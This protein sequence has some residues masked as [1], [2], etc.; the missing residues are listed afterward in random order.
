MC[1]E[2]VTA[3]ASARDARAVRHT[4]RVAVLVPMVA[5]A[6]GLAMAA[7][8]CTG[9]P[10]GHAQVSRP[11][12]SP[13]AS[14]AAPAVS[15]P[16]PLPAPR[17]RAA[18]DAVAVA[19][20]STPSQISV[21]VSRALFASSPV[22][23]VTSP[24]QVSVTTAAADAEALGVPLLLAAPPGSPAASGAASDAAS[25]VVDGSDAVDD[26][27]R[28]LGCVDALVVGEAPAPERVKIADDVDSLPPVSKPTPLTGTTVLVHAGGDVGA[29]AATATARAAGATVVPVRGVDPRADPRAIQQLAAVASTQV[30]AVGAD[31]GPAGTL[32]SRVAVAHA[33]AQLPGGGQLIFPGRRFVALYGHPGGAGLGVLGAQDAD[34]SVARAQQMAAQYQPLSE[35]PVVPT[36]EIIATVA[37]AS[38]GRD[39]DYSGEST[40]AE[41]EPWVAKA[42]AAGLYVVLDLQPGRADVLAQA[43]IYA[44][45]LELPNVG[46][47]I[48]PE[49]ALKPNQLPLHQ[50]GSI[51]AAVIN[52]VTAW[53]DAFTAA[54]HLPQKLVVLHQFRLSMIGDESKLKTD[55][56]NLALLIHMD[57]QGAQPS[58]NATWRAVVAAAPKG[59]PFG[60]KNFYK[61]DD[62]VLTPEQTMAHDP[63][64]MM[65]SYQ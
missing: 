2:P 64:P 33:G 3:P 40:I 41:L 6:L 26:E 35:V 1:R 21:A 22:V 19:D 59:V 13:P 16:A 61:E 23:V 31:F 50:I 63:K 18:F 38:A 48:D 28:R 36:F 8:A 43:K 37:Q 32:A 34:A 54:R 46:L 49:W 62:P 39:G 44:P 15:S 4:P 52:G 58:K 30:L 57:G 53:L 65:I 55:Y 5:V 14:S 25:D 45:L 42:S 51:D 7:S 27:V 12:V 10:S 47:A 29:V 56:D 9:H 60:W 24:D 17:P 11:P 20:G